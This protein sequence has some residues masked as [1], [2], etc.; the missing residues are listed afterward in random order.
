MV[1]V[2]EF[3]PLCTPTYRMGAMK[4]LKALKELSGFRVSLVVQWLRLHWHWRELRF[5]P[6]L[7]S[8]T[9]LEV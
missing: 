7:G 5:D 4:E 8:S 6:C 2:G 1:G 9:C 3:K